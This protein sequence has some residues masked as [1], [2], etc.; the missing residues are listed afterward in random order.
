MIVHV[1]DVSHPDHVAQK[2]EVMRTLAGMG[3][4]EKRLEQVI[5][6]CNKCDQLSRYWFFWTSILIVNYIDDGLDCK[7]TLCSI[8]VNNL[9]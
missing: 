5:E 1:R 2:A 8:I 4:G 3:L 6:V 9:K 7:T